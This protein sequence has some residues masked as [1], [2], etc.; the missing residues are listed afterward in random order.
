GCC[1]HHLS[2]LGFVSVGTSEL[3]SPGVGDG[4]RR[5]P[6]ANPAPQKRRRP[7]SCRGALDDRLWCA[8]S[9]AKKRAAASSPGN[10]ADQEKRFVYARRNACATDPLRPD[11]ARR[12]PCLFHPSRRFGHSPEI[13][14]RLSLRLKSTNRKTQDLPHSNSARGTLSMIRLVLVVAKFGAHDLA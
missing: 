1:V 5:R 12:C 2:H 6:H 9:R 10:S 7:H 13:L 11:R 14:V 4:S 8:P 3:H